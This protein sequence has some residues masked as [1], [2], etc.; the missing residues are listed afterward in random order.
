MLYCRNMCQIAE[1]GEEEK[2]GLAHIWPN[3][4]YL[5]K[6]KN[7]ILASLHG[8][9]VNRAKIHML[10]LGLGLKISNPPHWS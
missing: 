6:E 10:A 8:F 5:Q 7:G 1:P 3:F 9:K 2:V 4:R